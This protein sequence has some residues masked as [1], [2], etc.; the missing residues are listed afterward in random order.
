MRPTGRVSSITR[1][2][3]VITYKK[4]NLFDN[5]VEDKKNIILHVCNDSGGWGSG[6]VLAIN[7]NCG[8]MPR[9]SYRE[10]YNKGYYSK[11]NIPFKLGQI[12]VAKTDKDNVFV[13]NMIGQSTPRGEFFRIGRDG[14]SF[15]PF[16]PDSF[17]ECMYR[18]VQLCQGKN[19]NIVCPLMGCGLGGS[20]RDVV[21][22]I[23]EDVI[24][25]YINLTVW[26]L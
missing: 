12:Q 11:P 6:F 8:D 26:E 2:N 7:N 19:V 21:F 14:I 16:R 20:T 4:G 3:A 15:P 13:I 1:E 22:E 5:L 10:W 24:K 9:N 18:V 25:D 17:R 23:V